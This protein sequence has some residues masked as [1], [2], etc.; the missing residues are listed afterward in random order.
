MTKV[1]K[2][3]EEFWGTEKQPAYMKIAKD[4]NNVNS[5]AHIV[6]FEKEKS[7]KIKA[8]KE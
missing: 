6:R 2:P 7:K 5:D 3:S 4:K 8:K 1:T